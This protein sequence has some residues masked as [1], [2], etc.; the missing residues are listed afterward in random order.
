M[1]LETANCGLHFPIVVCSSL[2]ACE[3]ACHLPP[4]T[5]LWSLGSLTGGRL[6]KGCLRLRLLECMFEIE[7]YHSTYDNLPQIA[8]MA[9]PLVLQA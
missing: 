2:S 6:P 3:N 8:W 7:Q 1:H 4:C 5:S 9:L